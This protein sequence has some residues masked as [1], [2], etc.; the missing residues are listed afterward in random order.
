MSA[1][2]PTAGAPRTPGRRRGAGRRPAGTA[3]GEGRREQ[4]AGA[5]DPASV[6]GESGGPQNPGGGAEGQQQQE[7][8]LAGAR[9]QVR[10]LL[11]AQG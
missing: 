10:G 9:L 3:A 11:L 1:H 5:E 2:N 7:P 4:E 8:P 6:Q